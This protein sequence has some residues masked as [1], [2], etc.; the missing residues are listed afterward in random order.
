M[1]GVFHEISMDLGEAVGIPGPHDR[2]THD[3]NAV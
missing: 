2:N 3:T 1:S